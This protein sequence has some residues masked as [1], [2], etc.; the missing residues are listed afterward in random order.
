MANLQTNTDQTPFN[1]LERNLISFKGIFNILNSTSFNENFSNELFAKSFNIYNEDILSDPIDNAFGAQG[2]SGF[3]QSKTWSINGGKP[4]LEFTIGSGQTV[5][6]S[7]NTNVEKI[8]IPLTK[9][10]SLLEL[11]VNF[12]IKVI[13]PPLRVASSASASESKP[14]A[15]LAA[16][17]ILRLLYFNL[18]RAINYP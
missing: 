5:G 6:G 18:L 8:L 16:G 1:R 9:L 2:T 14:I 4:S 11:A 7:N 10:K 3:L 17:V 12:L 15:L 13:E